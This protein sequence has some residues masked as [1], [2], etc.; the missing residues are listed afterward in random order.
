MIKQP[1]WTSQNRE[2]GAADESKAGG[3]GPI[4]RG[5][6]CDRHR[7]N[8][9]LEDLRASTAKTWQTVFPWKQEVIEMC[10]H[11]CNLS[12]SELND[13]IAEHT[14][15]PKVCSKNSDARAFLR[16]PA[17]TGVPSFHETYNLLCRIEQ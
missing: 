3:P 5:C 12:I 4:P 15:M 1:D 16:C 17:D 10:Y 11:C 2:G 6:R 14:I 7:L 9:T 8:S 13:E